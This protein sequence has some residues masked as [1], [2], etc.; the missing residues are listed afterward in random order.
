MHQALEGALGHFARR[1]GGG[2]D[3]HHE[4]LTF[5]DIN[6]A[7]EGNKRAAQRCIKG[8]PVKTR[9]PTQV[10]PTVGGKSIARI[11]DNTVQEGGGLPHLRST[12]KGAKQGEE[13]RTLRSAKRG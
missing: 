12:T 8:A 2:G 5:A 10:N 9:G 4:H 13:E 1:R 3:C 6:S 11:K 7:K